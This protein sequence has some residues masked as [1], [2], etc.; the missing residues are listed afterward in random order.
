ME[1]VED[2]ISPCLMQM[3]ISDLT[4]TCQF[5]NRLP[6]AYCI[7]GG[8]EALLRR[9]MYL[10]CDPALPGLVHASPLARSHCDYTQQQLIDGHAA[11]D[12]HR[13]FGAQ[14]DWRKQ[15]RSLFFQYRR[16][17]SCFSAKQGHRSMSSPNKSNSPTVKYI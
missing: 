10:V 2:K 8:K 14:A 12:V 17:G 6:A 4:E 15:G 13:Y 11:L 1:S 7:Y 3:L 9:I 16:H 5:I